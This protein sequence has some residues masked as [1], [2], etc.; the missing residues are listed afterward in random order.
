MLSIII[1]SYQPSNFSQV[2]KSIQNT[3]GIDYEI[4]KVD[5]ANAMSIAQAY[6]IGAEKAKFPILCFLHEDVIFEI[7]NWGQTLLKIFE[8]ENVGVVGV[9][10]GI[11]KSN[12]LSGWSQSYKSLNRLDLKQKFNNNTVIQQYSN[13]KKEIFSEV[14]CLDGVF[15][16]VKKDVWKQFLFDEKIIKGYHGYDIDF[17]WSVSTKYNNYVAYGLGISIFHQELLIKIGT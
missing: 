5:N 17:S 12:V 3:I 10:G 7:K 8:L 16:A 14:V 11:L 2:I 13:P 4:I 9:A 15:L 6:N 1:S